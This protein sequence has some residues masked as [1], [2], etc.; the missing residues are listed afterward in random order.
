MTHLT[1]SCD[2]CQ[3]QGTAACDD[4]VVTFLC[5]PN[6]TGVVVDLDEMRALRL[7]GRSDLVPPLRHQRRAGLHRGC[8]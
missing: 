2:E 7:L 6:S 5:E 4:C 1:I 3:M 8:G